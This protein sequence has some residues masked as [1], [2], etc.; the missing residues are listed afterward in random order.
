MG[1]LCFFLFIDTSADVATSANAQPASLKDRS[2]I[3]DYNIDNAVYPNTGPQSINI[4]T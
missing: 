3:A 4:E 2:I 1:R